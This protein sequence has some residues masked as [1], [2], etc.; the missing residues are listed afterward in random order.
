MAQYLERAKDEDFFQVL[1]PRVV[2]GT[3]QQ[4]AAKAFENPE[5]LV[6]AQMAFWADMT[7][8]WQRSFAR[9]VLNQP[10]A[11]VIEPAPE[12][13]RFKS[14]LWVENVCSTR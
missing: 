8:L 1:D 3:F 4:L 10:I 2:T 9:A 7:N 13:K 12:D 6:R 14:E 5:A 11:P